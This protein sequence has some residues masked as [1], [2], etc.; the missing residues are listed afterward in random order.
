VGF[1]RDFEWT[2]VNGYFNREWYPR[3]LIPR[4]LGKIAAAY[5]GKATAAPGSQAPR[6]ASAAAVDADLWVDDIYLIKEV[7]RREAGTS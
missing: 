6:L 3:R 5:S 7:R 2:G 4:L 1:L